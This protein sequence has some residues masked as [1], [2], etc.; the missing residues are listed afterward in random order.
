MCL[1]TCSH[2]S[3]RQVITNPYHPKHDVKTTTCQYCSHTSQR[4]GNFHPK[5]DV[6]TTT[7]PYS[8]ATCSLTTA[9]VLGDTTSGRSHYKAFS[10]LQ[11][12]FPTREFSTQKRRHHQCSQE[13]PCSITRRGGT[14]THKNPTISPERGGARSRREKREND[15]A[16]QKWRTRRQPPDLKREPFATHS[17]KTNGYKK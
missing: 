2:T 11:P 4:Q 16:T 7:C 3:Q 15:D 10:K 6:K 13:R 12:H 5:H 1:A 8:Y 14:L 9:V 17:G